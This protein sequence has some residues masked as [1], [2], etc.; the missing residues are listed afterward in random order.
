MPSEWGRS[1]GNQPTTNTSRPNDADYTRSLRDYNIWAERYDPPQAFIDKSRKIL[2]TP[3]PDMDPPKARKIAQDSRRLREATET[4]MIT[5]LAAKLFPFLVD[6][7]SKIV[8]SANT[9]WVDAFPIKPRA[10]KQG[11]PMLSVPKPDAAFG[12]SQEYVLTPIQEQAAELLEDGGSS[13]A[14]PDGRGGWFPFLTMEFKAAATGGTR[15]VG[16][17]QANLAGSVMLLTLQELHARATDGDLSQGHEP[18]FF[19]IVMDHEVVVFNAHWLGRRFDDLTTNLEQIAIYRLRQ[20]EDVQLAYRAA[21]NIM[22]WAEKT[23]LPWI[24]NLLEKYQTRCGSGLVMPMAPPSGFKRRRST[25]GRGSSRG[26]SNIGNT[27]PDSRQSLAPEQVAVADEGDSDEAQ[28]QRR[29]SK[30]APT[31]QAGQGSFTSEVSKG[32]SQL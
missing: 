22:E 31:E 10:G 3:G 7:S 14:L 13:Y 26:S 8:Q 18:L 6:C 27:R 25:R 29:R 12:F 2:L 17:D 19:S 1:G 9:E 28:P 21:E 24:S 16:T 15:Y 4:V 11:A 20:P 5:S 32:V 23:Y 30:V